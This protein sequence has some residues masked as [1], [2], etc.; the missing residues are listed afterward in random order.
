M[1]PQGGD[2]ATKAEISG[3]AY[4]VKSP[5]PEDR[6]QDWELAGAYLN[7]ASQGRMV[8]VWHL[9]AIYNHDIAAVEVSVSAPGGVSPTEPSR[10]LFSA[11]DITEVALAFD[12]NMNPF[13]AYTQAGAAK[14][15]WYD[16]IAAAMVHTAMPA[17]VVNM[18]CTMDERREFNV[19]NSDIVLSYL[20]AGNL[21]IAYQRDRYQV[22]RVLRAGVGA[23]CELISMAL[24]RGYRLQWRLRKYELAD[25]PG[26]LLMTDPFL[27]DVV[28]GLYDRAGI[29][30]EY[31]DVN[32]LYDSI[33]E[34]FKVAT[35]GGADVMVQSLQTAYFFDP[36]ESDRQLRAIVRGGAVVMEIGADALVDRDDGPLTIDR[37][38][39]AELL[40]KVNVTM[41]DSSIDYTT[42]K[43]TAERRSNKIGAKAESSIEIPITASPDFQATVAM[44]RLNI[45]WG[46][47]QTYEFE[48]PIAYSAL[49][50]TDV[51]VL[52][53]KA[54]RRHRMRLMEIQEDGGVLICKASQDAPWVYDADAVGVQAPPPTPTTP[55]LVGDTTVVV[56]DIPVL[57]DQDDELGY[58]VGAAGTG[59]GWYGAEVQMSTDG[60]ANVGQSLQITIPSVIGSTLTA[61]QHEVSSEYLSA[62]TL[63]VQVPE[64]LESID[65]EALLRYGNRAALQRADGSWE[66]LQFQLASQVSGDTFKLSGLVRGRY[67]TRP[68]AVPVGARFVMIDDSLTFVQ[69]QQWM[70]GT[71]ISYRGVSY[72]QDSDEADWNVFAVDE[73][74]SQQEWPVHYVRALRDGSNNVTLTW[75]GRARLGVET[76]PRNSKYFAGYR[77][78][79]SDGFTADTTDSTH[80]RAATPAGVT[81]TVAALNTITGPG[82]A[83]EAITV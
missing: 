19:A 26:A 58:Y 60:G 80:A 37:V 39:E 33:V 6:L 78:S 29:S 35:E 57:R 73:P 52:T 82:P 59:K 63:I 71:T 10:V 23:D 41:V 54:G 4:P 32:H 40:R 24:N 64:P 12:Q 77:V 31:I 27:A 48:L 13:V 8:K 20:R 74:M 81:V 9:Q 21:C 47:M 34:G 65:R 56:L 72:G 62:Q 3:F 76:A 36:T 69:V 25:D 18:R 43:Q 67:A 14:I 61:L 44:R 75:I 22:E 5:L 46:E 66:V 79:Y 83:S 7:D 28:S 17:G 15:Y 1:L 2:L 16:P 45:A 50:P 55:G 70:T 11:P 53:D 38:Q 30:K 42:N 49:V 51:V 68:L